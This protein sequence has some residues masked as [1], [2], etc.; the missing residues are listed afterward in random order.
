MN[1]SGLLG[2]RRR[3]LVQPKAK[4]KSL[5][6]FVADCRPAKA[7]VSGLVL[8]PAFRLSFPAFAGRFGKID[9]AAV[10]D[11]VSVGPS[12]VDLSAAASGPVASCP[13]DFAAEGSVVSLDP[14]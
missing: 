2:C 14:V 3:C 7:R 11:L 10:A 6:G 1:L 13:F 12:V 8:N 4:A 5:A 9:P